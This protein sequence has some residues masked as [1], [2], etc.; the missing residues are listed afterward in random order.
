VLAEHA[1]GVGHPGDAPVE[2][3]EHHRRE[4]AVGRLL[5]AA[6]HRHHHR[7]EA[8]EQR[9]EREQVGQDVDALPAPARRQLDDVVGQLAVDGG[10][11]ARALGHR[12][13]RQLRDWST[14]RFFLI[15]GIIARSCSPTTSIG[16]SDIIGAWRA[17]SARRRGS[18]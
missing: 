17:A 6:V 11:D 12:R 4:D 8:A 7:V 15:H 13:S 14:S 10:D 3:V 9:A 1:L 5:E 18:R 2:A 16:C